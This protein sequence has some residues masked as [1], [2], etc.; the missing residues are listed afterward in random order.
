VRYTLN[1]SFLAPENYLEAAKSAEDAGFDTISI[2]DSAF[3][4]RDTSSRYPYNDDGGRA[5][6]E[7]APFLDAFSLIPAMAAVT[8]RIVF[9]SSVLKLPIRHPVITA[10]L[11]TST[12]VISGGRFKLGVGTSPWPEDYEVC[13]VPWEG[14]GQ[15]LEEQISIIRGLVAGGYHEH[16]GECYD[17]AP[18]KMLPVP[19][20]PVPILVGG[21]AKPA[22][23]RAATIADGWIAPATG[24]TRERL[25][26][27]IDFI[28]AE[29][30]AAGTTDHPFEIH[31][32]FDMTA[33]TTPGAALDSLG[34][35]AESGVT[36]ARVALKAG[37]LDTDPRRQLESLHAEIQRFASDVLS[38][39][40]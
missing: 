40:R 10:K 23:R 17:F 26:A 21:H 13:E 32:S 8:R 15:R 16:H 39:A 31:A 9:V 18:I 3:F 11:V 6:F 2:S 33:D 34:E 20:R 28:G 27:M 1:L 7:N 14:R 19:S 25:G 29:R 30:A 5:H 4:P 36:D 38:A 37:L 24:V 12:A 35:L 22:L